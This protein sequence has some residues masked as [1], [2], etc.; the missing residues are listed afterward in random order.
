[1]KFNTEKFER[2]VAEAK[3][4][5]ADN[6]RWINAIDK[7]V[8]GLNGTWIVTEL[9]EGLLITT[10]SGETYHANGKCGCRAYQ[11]NQPCKHRAAVKLVKRYNEMEAAPVASPCPGVMVKP[12]PTGV[13][14]G[15]YYV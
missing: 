4:K 5:A 3:R 1:M 2:V 7:A 11:L 13:R 9:M 14:C 15:A 6:K 12:Q 10:E 8:E